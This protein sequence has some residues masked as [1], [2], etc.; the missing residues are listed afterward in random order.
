MQLRIFFEPVHILVAVAV[1]LETL[2]SSGSEIFLCHLAATSTGFFSHTLLIQPH[3]RENRS[4]I[5]FLLSFPF[6][7]SQL[8]ILFFISLPRHHYQA[9]G[10][11]KNPFIFQNAELWHFNAC[12]IYWEFIIFDK[13]C[14]IKVESYILIRFWLLQACSCKRN[15]STTGKIDRIII[16]VQILFV[17][18]IPAELFEN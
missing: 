13:S 9:N 1:C 18:C 16:F 10:C 7:F 12:E 15:F 14:K 6:F 8:F 17:F 4:V 3:S 11:K 5:L 2:D